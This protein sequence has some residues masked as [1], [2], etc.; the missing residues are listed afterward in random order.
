MVWPHSAFLMYVHSFAW[1]GG[2]VAV[3]TFIFRRVLGTTWVAGLAA[4]LFA[5]DDAHGFPAAW[6]ANRKTLIGAFFGILALIAHDRWRRGEWRIG[7]LVAPLSLLL[8]LLAKE[9]VAGVGA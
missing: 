2:L 6:L 5:V 7:S 8:G 1:L 4:L 9:S 3:A